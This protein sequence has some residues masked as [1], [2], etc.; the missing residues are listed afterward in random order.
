MKLIELAGCLMRTDHI[1]KE[2]NILSVQDPAALIGDI[3][4][5]FYDFLKVLEIAG[6]PTK[7]K[8]IFMGDYVDRGM[9]SCEVL[10]LLYAMKICYPE[11]VIL[12][13][14]NHEC[15]QMTL[16]F[17]F[18]QECLS[19]YDSEVY[20]AVMD[21]F[22]SM[23][24]ACILNGRYFIVHGGL[25]PDAK[26]IDDISRI[27][28]LKETPRSGIMCDILWSDPTE[29]SE[30][31]CDEA[32]EENSSRG[33]SFIYSSQACQ[34]FLARNSLLTVIRAHEAQLEGYRFY[35]WAGCG[36]FPAVITLFSAPN[37]C[38]IYKNKGAIAKIRKGQLEI[39]QFSY[40]EQP[41]TLPDFK[42]AFSWSFPFLA[43]KILAIFLQITKKT[44]EGSSPISELTPR[45]PSFSSESPELTRAKSLRK[46]VQS[47]SKMFVIYRKICDNQ[48]IIAQLKGLCPDNRLPQ[49]LL[50]SEQGAIQSA[51]ETF[52][53][54]K[55]LDQLNERMPVEP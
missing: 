40:S 9:F 10:L 43:E 15:R 38:N 30:G 8:L 44:M 35:N 32:F 46:K 29:N 19:K 14:G 3:H 31:L 36:S 1:G 55:S 47:I 52:M 22:D 17:N 24:L 27:K 5:Q 7:N 4:G 12:L 2:P 39:K 13:R 25:S 51:L 42:D 23:P 6:H 20:E 53:K 54:A 45:R 37:Y 50:L 16:F 11:R 33:C 26:T 49:G 41:F 28:R 21:S 18:R 34:R 48:Q